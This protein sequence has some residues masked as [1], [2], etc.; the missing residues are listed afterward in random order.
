MGEPFV[1]IGKPIRANFAA[2]E[3]GREKFTRVC[4]EMD[5]SKPVVRKVWIQDHWH[6]VVF[7][8]LHLIYENCGCYGHVTRS[9]QLQ[10]TQG[11]K[12]VVDG[13]VWLLLEKEAKVQVKNNDSAE[14]IGI[15]NMNSHVI[16]NAN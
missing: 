13:R 5:L 14:I 16:D 4:V 9:C 6:R 3:M 8:S 1:I 15:S 12:Q 7:E 10:K 2:K 11:A